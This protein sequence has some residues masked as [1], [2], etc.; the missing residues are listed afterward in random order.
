LWQGD[1]VLLIKHTMFRLLVF[2]RTTEYNAKKRKFSTQYK[3]NEVVLDLLF[4][5]EMNTN[6][7]TNAIFTQF[8]IPFPSVLYSERKNSSNGTG[9]NTFHSVYDKPHPFS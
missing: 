2:E 8:H 6:H 3:L 1:D 9:G 7:N 4:R 5:R